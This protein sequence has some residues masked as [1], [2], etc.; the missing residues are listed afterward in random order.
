MHRKNATS[1]LA[2]WPAFLEILR[3][4]IVV[5]WLFLGITSMVDGSRSDYLMDESIQRILLP[6]RISWIGVDEIMSKTQLPLKIFTL[7]SKTTLLQLCSAKLP[8]TKILQP[9]KKANFPYICEII[10]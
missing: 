1:V 8:L 5:S 4:C 3:M 9:P 6:S 10:E 2:I 7:G